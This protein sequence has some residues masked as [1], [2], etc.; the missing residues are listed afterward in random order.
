MLLQDE[1]YIIRLLTQYGVLA[2]AQ[3]IRLLRD[4]QP[5]TAEKIIANLKR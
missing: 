1:Q 2:R 4:K 5:K 3:V